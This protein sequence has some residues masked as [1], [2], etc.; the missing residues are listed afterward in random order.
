MTR[1]DQSTEN[2][3]HLGEA[4]LEHR[5]TTHSRTPVETAE[6]DP[7]PFGRFGKVRKESNKY[8]EQGL[9]CQQGEMR[10]TGV[11]L[12][13]CDSS[14]KR[15]LALGISRFLRLAREIRCNPPV[16][17][18]KLATYITH[19]IRAT[20]GAYRVQYRVCIN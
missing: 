7:I 8:D 6:Q 15:R 11:P 1:P 19:R 18:S 13:K 16:T 5:W 3:A 20:P 10:H 17:I 12:Q 14:H 9:V 2:A 4:A